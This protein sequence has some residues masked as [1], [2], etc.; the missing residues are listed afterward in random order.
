MIHGIVGTIAGLRVRMTWKNHILERFHSDTRASDIV[1]SQCQI[2]LFVN[3]QE[4]SRVS[5]VHPRSSRTIITARQL[6]GQRRIEGSTHQGTVGQ[7]QVQ[8]YRL[9]EYCI[10]GYNTNRL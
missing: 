9:I 1:T 4:I 3:K 8:A 6:I 2:R 5:V 7:I 10:Y